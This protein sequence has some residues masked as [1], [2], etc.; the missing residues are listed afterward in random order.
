M[1]FL[2]QNLLEQDI[3]NKGNNNLFCLNFHKH[4]FIIGQDWYNLLNHCLNTQRQPHA[5]PCGV[6]GAMLSFTIDVITPS[7]SLF[8]YWVLDIL[9]KFTIK[10]H[11]NI[12]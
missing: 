11:E 7:F 12:S 1:I 4:I 3:S 2:L 10:S 9:D 8:G 6:P 5:R